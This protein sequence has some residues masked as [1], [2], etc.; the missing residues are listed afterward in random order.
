MVG[1][2]TDLGAC[3]RGPLERAPDPARL[4]SDPERSRQD[5][6]AC[7]LSGGEGW[8]QALQELGGA[9]ADEEQGLMRGQSE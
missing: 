9:F 8:E 7:F 5:A 2:D 3:A 4:C 6:V 1:H